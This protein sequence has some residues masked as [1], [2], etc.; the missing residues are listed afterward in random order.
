MC[1]PTGLLAASGVRDSNAPGAMGVTVPGVLKF[2]K[3]VL[4]RGCGNR[5]HGLTRH[6]YDSF[7]RKV[8]GASRSEIGVYGARFPC[9]PG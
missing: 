4:N 5:K 8:P 7:R 1:G 6:D 2:T 3:K 9:A